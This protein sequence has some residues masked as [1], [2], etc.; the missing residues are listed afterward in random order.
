M[1]I[2]TPLSYW[3]LDES[4]G[5]A[6][7]SVASLSAV[8]TS[9]TYSAGKINN[10]A[11]YNGSAYH[12]IA[13]NSAIKPTS[14]ISISLWV[15]ITSTSSYQMLL[16]KGENAGDTRSY[17]IR[18]FSTTTKIEVQ[19]RTG[20]GSYVS[21]RS[22]TAIGTGTWK[23]IVITRTGATNKIYIDGVSDTL[24]SN[25]TQT[26]SIDYNSD[27]L[28]FGQ[29]NG[30]FRFN[31]KLDEIGIWNVALSSTEVSELYNSGSGLQYPFATN[32][33]VT[34][35]AVNATFA[36]PTYTPSATRNVSLT[37]NAVNATFT[38][39][40][41]AITGGATL[42]PAT[43]NATFGIPAYSI[44]TADTTIYPDTVNATFAIP[45]YTP[46]AEQN[47]EVTVSTVNATFAIP[48]YTV[49]VT[50]SVTIAPSTVN[51]TFSILT[52]SVL[53]DFWNNKFSDT[54][55]SWSDKLSASSDTWNNKY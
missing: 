27:S 4:S 24:E 15:N 55:D 29:R 45:A 32:A 34:P 5:D 52:Y 54:P 51:A 17:E 44:T 2:T 9:V 33:T 35:S 41:V 20:G 30:G 11:V 18:C 26:T 1:S 10:G 49:S 25:T 21:F 13:D 46:T 53:G 39:Q 8:N 7:D 14:D 42:S 22:T 16:A 50:A 23:H 36:I 38:A 40:T 47:T 37:P 6:T 19:M 12:T 31:G 28:W 43:V 48:A 3:K